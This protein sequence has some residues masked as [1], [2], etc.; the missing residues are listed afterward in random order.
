MEA[1]QIS[2]AVIKRLPRYYRYLGE[3]L[4][5]NVERISS[6]D[7][8]KKMR[9]FLEKTGYDQKDSAA[10]HL[11]RNK[12]RFPDLRDKVAGTHDRSRYQLGKERYVKSI[13][14]KIGQRLYISPVNVDG[15]A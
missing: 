14:Q 1:K 6:N 9:G 11:L 7:L 3:L 10:E 13:I 8:S 12:E 4:E 15:V 2:K 5:D